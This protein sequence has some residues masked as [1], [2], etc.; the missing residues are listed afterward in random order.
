MTRVAIIYYSA[1]GN[2]HALAEGIREGAEGAGAEVRLRRV[3]ETASPEAIAQNAKWQAH[4]EATREVPEA[5][6]AD[7]EWC[8][9]VIFGSPTRFGNVTAQLKQ[10]IDATGGLWAQGKLAEKVGSGFTS[11]STPHGGHESTLIALYNT[12][13]NWG[14]II[15]PPGYADPVQYKSGT[16]MGTSHTSAGG[17]RPGEIELG[18]ARFQGRRVAEVTSRLLA[19]SRAAATA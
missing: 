19:G 15:I 17:A 13:Y 11:A 3:R 16:P 6:L 18:A 14:C 2:V 5:T 1:T 9:A 12:F 4:R 8:D 10:F 7:L